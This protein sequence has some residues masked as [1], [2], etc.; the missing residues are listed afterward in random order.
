MS[1]IP[2]PSTTEI[3]CQALN[4]RRQHQQDLF[5]TDTQSPY[6]W[7]LSDLAIIMPNYFDINT[8]VSE[9]TIYK[10]NSEIIKS[11]PK[12]RDISKAPI[13]VLNI[14]GTYNIYHQDKNQIRTIHNGKDQKISNVACEYL[15]RQINGT[16][17]QQAYFLD[18]TKTTNEIF[19]LS[20]ELRFERVRNQITA[21]TKLLSAIINRAYGA[22]KFS[23]SNTWSLIW[24][25]LY[26]FRTMDELRERYNLKSSPIDYMSPNALNFINSM[27]QEIILQFS[28]KPYYHIDEVMRY[29]ANKASFCRIQFAR[30]GIKPENELTTNNSY[31]RIEKIHQMRI[32]SW[33]KYY[34]LSL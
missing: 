22:R 31:N 1:K 15:L 24:T 16:E 9:N 23:F 19:N 4:A 6:F 3:I 7:K 20:Q 18:P 30:Y 8:P 26:E 33:E 14:R 28:G 29:A 34:M 13:H 11:V 21:N 32:K 25:K 27:L 12:F 2:Y 10:M 17:I 5:S